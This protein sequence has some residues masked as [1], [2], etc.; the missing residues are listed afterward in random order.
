MVNCIDYNQLLDVGTF[1]SDTI[2]ELSNLPTLLANGKAELS[3]MNAVECGSQ[4]VC[5]EDG[6]VY[7]LSG[8]NEW[9]VLETNV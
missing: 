8:N 3:N 2:S 9:V 7:F 6:N 1:Y 5:K 4:C